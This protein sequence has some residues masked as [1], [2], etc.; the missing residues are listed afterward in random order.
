MENYSMETIAKDNNIKVFSNCRTYKT[1]LYKPHT[2]QIGD[3]LISIVYY[4]KT[5]C[6]NMTLFAIAKDTDENEYEIMTEEHNT[7]TGFLAFPVSPEK[8]KGLFPWL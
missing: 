2:I 1:G 6:S 8:I 7:W 4:P 3:K 5:Y